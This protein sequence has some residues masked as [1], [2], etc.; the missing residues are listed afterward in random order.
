MKNPAK[1]IIRISLAF[2]AFLFT[3]C[4]LLEQDI[5]GDLSA[6]LSVYEP[7]VGVMI[8]YTDVILVDATSNKNIKDNLDKIKKWQ[9]TE[10]SYSI[11]NYSGDPSVTFSGSIGFSKRSSTLG[12]TITASVTNLNFSSV[13]DNNKKYKIDLSEND[14]NTIAGYFESEQGILVYLDGLLSSGQV[15]LDVKIFAKVRVK[16]KVL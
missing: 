4:S 8:P 10:L 6:I 5:D 11:M 16:A 1:K 2:L 7:K 3:N 13:S 14:L 15:Q 12:A 9:V